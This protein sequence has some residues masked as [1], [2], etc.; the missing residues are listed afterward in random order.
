MGGN[1]INMFTLEPGQVPEPE[2]TQNDQ[3]IQLFSLLGQNVF[4][5]K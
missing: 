4:G 1:V 3:R 2:W 5:L